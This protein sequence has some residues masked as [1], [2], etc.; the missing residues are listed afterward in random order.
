MFK[1]NAIGEL[2]CR[3][4]ELSEV[5]K[6][7][8]EDY[9][10]VTILDLRNN[11]LITIE[12][13]MVFKLINLKIL[14]LRS[15]QIEFL[16]GEIGYLWN[17][18]DLR[19]DSNHLT[20]LPLQLF[21]LQSLHMLSVSKNFLNSFQDIVYKLRKLHY[22]NISFNQIKIVPDTLTKLKK[23]SH[24]Y[25]Q[26]N[27]FTSLPVGLFTHGLN[28]LGLEWFDYTNPIVLFQDLPKP[29]PVAASAGCIGF[30]DFLAC[31]NKKCEPADILY[32]S[33]HRGDIGVVSSLISSNIDVNGFDS[34]GYSPLV[35]SIKQDKVSICRMLIGA[36][37]SFRYGAGSYG[38]VLHIAVY[39]CEIWLIEMILLAG[40]DVNMIDA[41]G[42]TPLHILMGVF[43]RQKFKC[44]RIGDM[45]MMKN[46][47]VNFY[48]HE[49][50][51]PLHIASRKGF[52]SAIK[53]IVKKN[54]I[55]IE[56]KKEAF[57]LNIRGGSL[58]WVPLHL[59]SHSNDF[60]SIEVL[61]QAGAK[62][63]KTNDEG[64]TPKDTSKG[65]AAIYKYLLRLELEYRRIVVGRKRDKVVVGVNI[66]E[67]GGKKE[68]IYWKYKTLYEVFKRQ[69]FQEISLI[70]KEE[71][72]CIVAAEALHLMD[73]AKGKVNYESICNSLE[74]GR[75]KIF[76][77]E[78]ANLS[79][80]ISR[81][82]IEKSERDDFFG[83]G[84]KQIQAN[85]LCRN[86]IIMEDA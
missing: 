8:C 73:Y 20:I 62:I 44:K 54:K 77:I 78:K 26:S 60:N 83:S 36:G 72:D 51:T 34:D 79:Y 27:S 43:G 45:L 80:N 37:A 75:N 35:I 42:N 2:S 24:V 63:Y 31:F 67:K 69:D 30:M 81:Q 4:L 70:V 48:N 39:K 61:I 55:L 40:V 28:E 41:E 49:N 56:E 86:V 23:L 82:A 18:R 32:L 59:A 17:L 76:A 68:A 52:S 5:P 16:P 14:D 71:K 6:N 10:K 47:L 3:D 7:L 29:F 15:N 85:I 38:S 21:Q 9:E 33:I 11:Y 50:W 46:P 74:C 53:W 13:T 57:D 22:I 66:L 58:N 64:K 25:L 1:S 19:L 84:V 65:N 12:N